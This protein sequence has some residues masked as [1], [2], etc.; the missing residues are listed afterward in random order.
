M[1]SDPQSVEHVSRVKTQ[2]EGAPCDGAACSHAVGFARQSSQSLHRGV[3]IPP[4][5]PPP[6]WECKGKHVAVV[7][8]DRLKRLRAPLMA[9]SQTAFCTPRRGVNIG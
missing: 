2:G 5:P 1:T 4:P 7:G 6:R 8:C 3:S 9:R